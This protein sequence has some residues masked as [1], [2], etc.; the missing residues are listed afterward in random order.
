MI[1]LGLINFFCRKRRI[2]FNNKIKIIAK[3]IK[4]K[5]IRNNFRVLES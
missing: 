2:G 1:I 4:R 5:E 3:E